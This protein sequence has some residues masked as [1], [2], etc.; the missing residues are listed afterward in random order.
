MAI[1]YHHQI[2]ALIDIVESIDRVNRVEELREYFYRHSG[3]ATD[4][5]IEEG[6][7]RLIPLIRVSRG[8]IEG[9]I[10]RD[11]M[12]QEFIEIIHEIRDIIFM[13]RTRNENQKEN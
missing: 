6:E 8:L 4:G 2:I 11:N 1:Q 10:D 3:I 5:G 9:E 13:V 12:F 7:G